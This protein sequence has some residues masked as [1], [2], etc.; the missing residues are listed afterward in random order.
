MAGSC[1]P[2]KKV[3]HASGRQV[4]ERVCSNGRAEIVSGDGYYTANVYG[5]DGKWK[6]RVSSKTLRATKTKA[7]RR[8]S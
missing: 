8:I 3:Q 6:D 2:W 4:H 1:T 7:S 5:R